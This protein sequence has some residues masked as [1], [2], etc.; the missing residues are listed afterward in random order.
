[1]ILVDHGVAQGVAG[2]ESARS[3]L[4]PECVFGNHVHIGK[5]GFCRCTAKLS[6]PSTVADRLRR[7]HARPRLGV[8]A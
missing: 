7:R 5:C 4:C 3:D 1:M 2:G 8:A 6:M